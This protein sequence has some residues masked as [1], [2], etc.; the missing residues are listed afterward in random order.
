MVDSY[1]GM[2]EQALRKLIRK[3]KPQAFICSSVAAEA[4]LWLNHMIDQQQNYMTLNTGTK[5]PFD[6]LY[7]SPSTLGADRI[8]AVAGSISLLPGKRVLAIDCGSCITYDLVDERK[9]YY[10]GSISPGLQ[11]RCRAMHTFTARLPLVRITEQD[12]I[13]LRAAST[14]EALQSGALYGTVAEITQMIRMYAD[15]YG[16][17]QVIISGGD[18]QLLSKEVKVPHRAVPELIFVGLNSI[19]EYN[20]NV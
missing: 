8:A 13:N 17:L 10:G 11:M 6:N 15:K 4:P 2:D 3:V 7:Q 1:S 20:V 19:L 5:L 14:H 18:A 12:N 9:E 16:A